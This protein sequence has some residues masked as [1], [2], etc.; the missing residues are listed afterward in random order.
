MRGGGVDSLWNVI[1]TRYAEKPES[2][3]ALAGIY[4]P[5]R[6]LFVDL[7]GVGTALRAL[8]R[9]QIASVVEED[10]GWHVVQ[11]AD[12]AEEGATPEMS[13]IKG[14]LARRVELQLRKEAYARR[15]Q[16]LRTEAEGRNAIQYGRS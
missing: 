6:N 9:G 16:R 2:S 14:E 3:K 1:A 5:E 13:W 10:S 15:V 8:G 7:P 4:V 12:R 11:L